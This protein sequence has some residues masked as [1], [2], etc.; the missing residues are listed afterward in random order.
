MDNTPTHLA[1][2]ATLHATSLLASDTE[3][4]SE[5]ALLKP[6]E[7]SNTTRKNTENYVQLGR[8]KR[9]NTPSVTKATESDNVSQAEDRLVLTIIV[10][11]LIPCG[12]SVEEI[13]G[14]VHII[15]PSFISYVHANDQIRF[16]AR[17]K[18]QED[19]Q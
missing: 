1:Q 17:V 12:A 16:V 3:T 14:R 19:E 18:Y 8:R 10:K 2:T 7:A 4:T 9:K 5:S 11:R 6:T 15:L 13:D